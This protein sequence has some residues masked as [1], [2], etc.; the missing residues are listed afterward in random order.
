MGAR[1]RTQKDY[2]QI[3]GL[4]AC[5]T[6]EEIKRAYRRLALQYHPDR[7]PGDP[8]AAE[9]FKEISEAYAVLVDPAK[10]R[11]YDAFRQAQSRQES[12]TGR[13]WSRE[14]IFRDLFANPRSADLFEELSQEFSRL[15]FR[16]DDRF[17]RDT[18]F[19]GRGIFFGGV[20]IF[21][22]FGVRRIVF[23]PGREAMG[24]RRRPEMSAEP[25][26]KA[27]PSFAGF[28]RWLGREVKAVLTAPVERM[29][30]LLALG[31]GGQGADLIQTLELTADEVRRGGKKLVVINRDG[32]VEE[33]LVTIPP[34]IRPGTRLRL[35]GRG[36]DGGDLYLK[37]EV[38]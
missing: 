9:H 22:P 4:G 28:L 8:Q 2:Y 7:N 3:L 6:E 14:D 38:K 35:R 19:G 16:F 13:A 36:K 23:R 21:G 1:S 20:V 31:S 10:R 30:Q 34:S 37:V 15:G 32:R 26:S 29:R 11:E 5:A 17:F 25:P 24:R 33:L 18:F 12:F 27:L